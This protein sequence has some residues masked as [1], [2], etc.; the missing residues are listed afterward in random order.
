MLWKSLSLLLT[1]SYILTHLYL[2]IFH[3]VVLP[4]FHIAPP[5]SSPCLSGDSSPSALLP[6]VISLFFFH[7]TLSCLAI[8]QSA[9]LL[10]QELHNFH[11]VQNWSTIWV[12]MTSNMALVQTLLAVLDTL[13]IVI[14]DQL[15]THSEKCNST[16]P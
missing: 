2:S 12:H 5:V 9:S 4:F 8:E 10:N 6:S 11:S 16:V 3:H 1:R 14:H 7:L 13:V 15:C